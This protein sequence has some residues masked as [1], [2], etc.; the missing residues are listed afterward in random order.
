M[1]TI[2]Y[3]L[4][5]LF[6]TTIFAQ[7]QQE[8]RIVDLRGNWKFEIGDQKKY[9]DPKFDDSKWAEIF[10]PA[11]WE[12]E[13]YPGYDGFG[14]YRK[15]FTLPA[16]AKDH[17]LY[18][19]IIADDA[20]V[21]YIN[22]QLIGEGGSC[23]P[24]YQT[25]YNIEHKFFI[26]SRFLNYGKENIIAVRVYDETLNGGIVRGVTG[27]YEHQSE[28][29]IVVQ[30]PETWKFKRGDSELWKDPNFDDSKWQ[31]LI[32]PA[33]WDFQG[34][35]DYDGFGWYRVSF[36]MPSQLKDENVVLLLGRIDD[37]DQTYVNGELIGETGRIRSNGSVG[38]IR[39][40]YRELRGYKIPN[41]IIKYGQKNII[42][43]RVFDSMLDGGIYEGP[44]G[45][46]KE[47]DYKQ[48]KRKSEDQY[49]EERNKF[50]RFLDKIFNE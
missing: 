26:P 34:H 6:I 40:E 48:F 44:V 15:R 20:C 33:K 25:A 23:P 35:R 9:A 4:A 13:G 11:D 46:M 37:I 12:N 16:E 38:R 31:E 41:A 30:L 50:E 29:N 10:V 28:S 21:V 27:I 32:V 2:Q 7:A 36:E 17:Q 14:W 8:K 45:I 43:V 1:K 5:A 47:K 39:E 3:I 24:Q 18:L 49:Y 42:A 22:G 19:H